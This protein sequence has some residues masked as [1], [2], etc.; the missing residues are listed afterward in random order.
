[1]LNGDVVIQR[2][3]PIFHL[4]FNI[5]T[6]LRNLQKHENTSRGLGLLKIRQFLSLHYK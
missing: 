1:M 5:Q 4:T 3:S 6:T 2:S